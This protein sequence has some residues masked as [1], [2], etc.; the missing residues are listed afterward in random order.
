LTRQ[1]TLLACDRYRKSTRGHFGL[2][3]RPETEKKHLL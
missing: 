3:L 2:L 1:L